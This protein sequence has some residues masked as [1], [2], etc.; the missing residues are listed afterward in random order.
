MTTEYPQLI[1][2]HDDKRTAYSLDTI[3]VDKAR[4][5]IRE[6]VSGDDLD[7]QLKCLEL[8]TR[9][10]EETVSFS[11]LPRPLKPCAHHPKS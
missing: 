3:A 10:R 4:Q 8:E 2:M 6:N 1:Y 11:R 5:L 7:Q 9:T